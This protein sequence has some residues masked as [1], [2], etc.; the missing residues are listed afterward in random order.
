MDGTYFQ[1]FGENGFG[2][3]KGHLEGHMADSTSNR[4]GVSGKQSPVD[5]IQTSG[6]ESKCTATHQIRT[7]RSVYK[8]SSKKMVKI[9]EPN[10]LRV[11]MPRRACLNLANPDCAKGRPP[12]ADFPKWSSRSSQH[13]DMLNLDIKVP[14][15]HT[16]N[17]EVFDAEMQLLHLHMEDGR[18]G[19]IGIPIRAKPDAFNP[20]YQALLDQFQRVYDQ[21]QAQCARRR[22][23]RH[24]AA[25]Q[26]SGETSDR[27][28]LVEESFN[29]Y[30]LFMKTV[31]FYRYHGSN[32]EPPCLPISWFVMDVPLVISYKQLHQTKVLLFTNVNGWTCQKTSVHNS[33][34][35]VVRPIQP[36]GIVPST[37][38]RRDVMH[39][40]VGDF[41]PD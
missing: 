34:Q 39:C 9:I 16:I 26:Y 19:Y 27:N 30:D 18:M 41:L 10:K 15:E 17:G 7:R 4:C 31:F 8:L 29:P 3:W 38:Q 22:G 36:L 23:L 32:T 24:R 2:V 1:E 28:L 33:E 20:E 5:L 12:M 14:G 11:I 13:S 37:R 40:H 35:S 6:P 21:S 25:S